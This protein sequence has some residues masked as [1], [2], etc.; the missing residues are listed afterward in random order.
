MHYLQVQGGLL[1]PFH[2][3]CRMVAFLEEILELLGL[4]LGLLNLI[5]T[6]VTEL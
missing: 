4:C 1:F 6:H 5:I 3:Y 2:S